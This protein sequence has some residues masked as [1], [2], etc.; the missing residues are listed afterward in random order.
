MDLGD[1]EKGGNS[2][3]ILKVKERM[4]LFMRHNGLGGKE[5]ALA[6]FTALAQEP[7]MLQALSPSYSSLVPLLSF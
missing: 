4:A 1:G 6:K 3:F 7:T 5:A 2:G